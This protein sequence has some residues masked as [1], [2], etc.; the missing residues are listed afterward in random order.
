M[1][2]SLA[3]VSSLSLSSFLM[4]TGC[5]SGEKTESTGTASSSA[6][7]AAPSPPKT[8]FVPLDA[9]TLLVK[10]DVEAITKKSSGEPVKETVANLVTCSFPDPGS[11]KLPNG[12]QLGKLIAGRFYG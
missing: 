5:S 7:P 1:N 4:L 11:P 6:N 12:Q 8:A 9:C 3:I 2:S 10:A